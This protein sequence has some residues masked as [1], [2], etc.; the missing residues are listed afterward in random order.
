MKIRLAMNRETNLVL[1]PVTLM[2]RKDLASVSPRVRSC[3]FRG[4]MPLHFFSQYSDNNCH[5]E[6][7]SH[8]FIHECGCVPYQYP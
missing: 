8:L 1:T 5:I 7:I 3:A 6:C 4:E 2:S